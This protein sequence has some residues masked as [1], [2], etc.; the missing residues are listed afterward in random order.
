MPDILIVED[1]E[2]LRTML[3]KTLEARDYG[4]VEAAD[5]YEARRR[6]Q[7]ARFAAVLTDLR[8]PPAAGSRCSRPRARPTPR[9]PS[10]S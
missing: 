4:V 5:V 3:R 7:S 10:S 6:V 2:S 9:C 1:K 8:L